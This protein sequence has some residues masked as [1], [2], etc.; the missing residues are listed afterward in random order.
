M[1]SNQLRII[2]EMCP[3]DITVMTRHNV[4]YGTL[5]N[6]DACDTG[7]LLLLVIEPACNRMV[8]IDVSAVEAIKWR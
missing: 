7:L 2:F 8:A 1:T 4:F 6:N 3:N 5:Q